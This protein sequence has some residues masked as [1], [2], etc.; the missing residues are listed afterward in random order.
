MHAPVQ[1]SQLCTMIGAN[2]KMQGIP[3][4][5][6]QFVLVGKPCRGVKTFLVHGNDIKAATDEPREGALRGQPF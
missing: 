1:S 2:G 5:Q 4:P 3:A 6:R